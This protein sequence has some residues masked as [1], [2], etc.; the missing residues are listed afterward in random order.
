MKDGTFWVLTDNGFGV[1]ATRRD[2]MLMF[3]HVRVDWQRATVERVETV[4]LHDPD[5]VIPFHDGERGRRAKRYLTGT[6]LDIESMQPS[7][8]RSSSATSSARI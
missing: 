4:F 5:R 3:H 6:D 2:A 1:R 8:T 7:A